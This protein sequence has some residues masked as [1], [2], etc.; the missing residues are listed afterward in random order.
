M[1]SIVAVSIVS[2]FLDKSLSG[3]E[4]GRVEGDVTSCAFRKIRTSGV[5]VSLTLNGHEGI[6]FR[7]LIKSE[8]KDFYKVICDER[9]RVV[10]DYYARAYRWRG[11]LYLI[12]GIK[13]IKSGRALVYQA[14]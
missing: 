13:D 11:S 4:E 9:R 2:V 10:V 1:A 6:E 3:V 7:R 5:S 12:S 8:D 14:E